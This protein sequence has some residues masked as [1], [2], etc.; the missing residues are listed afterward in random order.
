MTR[1]EAQTAV[2]EIFSLYEQY[3]A[4]DYIGEPVSQVEHM[5]QAAQL[6]E[7]EGY[8]EEVILA[9]FFHDI[10]HLCEYIFVVQSMDGYGTVDHEGLG[11]QYLREKGFSDKIAKLVESHVAAKR[12]LTYKHPDYHH[13][14][15]EASKITL[16]QQGGMMN[17]TEA[18]QFE[19]DHL[20]PLFIKIRE[21]DDK[22]KMEHVPLPSLEIYKQ[23]AF[24]HLVSQN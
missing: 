16:A 21:W 23:M 14:L 22:A 2:D 8:D 1:E 3:G 6:A 5:C 13:K 18:K 7:A 17:E 9:A 11:G 20:H 4:A 15:S 12:Y 24:Q 10:G 19:E